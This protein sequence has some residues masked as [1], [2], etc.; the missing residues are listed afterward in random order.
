[1][2]D[3]LKFIP[4]R[5]SAIEYLKSKFPALC[6]TSGL[7]ERVAGRLYTITTL[8][9]EDQPCAPVQVMEWLPI[10]SAPKG[11]KLIVGYTNNNGKWRTVLAQYWLPDTLESDHTE[12]G[13][14]DEG[15]YEST[16]AYEELAPID[17]EPTHWM[18][19]P[20]PLKE[21]K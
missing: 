1:M 3:N 19:L 11:Q 14:A 15:W 21:P 4:V 7:C 5:R 6:E 18:P 12:N 2:N 16:E 10:E 17:Y 8:Q 13:F 20:P 9:T